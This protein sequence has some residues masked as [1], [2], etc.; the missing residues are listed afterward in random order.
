MKAVRKVIVGN[1]RPN[2]CNVMDSK[3]PPEG[4]LKNVT[5]PTK[6]E[7]PKFIVEIRNHYWGINTTRS[8]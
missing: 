6:S 2:T 1:I 5:V 3:T 4:G 7:H 8:I